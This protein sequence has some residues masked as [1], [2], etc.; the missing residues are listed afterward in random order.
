MV[1]TNNNFTGLMI[2]LLISLLFS[3]LSYWQ[4]NRYKEKLSLISTLQ[5]RIKESPLELKN[6]SANTADFQNL[7]YRRVVLEGVFKP[8]Y[9]M[10]VRNRR[11]KNIS[12]VLS[13]IP[14]QIAET[15]QIV[16]VSRG[17]IPLEYSNAKMRKKFDPDKSLT[18]DLIGIVKESSYQKLFAPSDPESGI[19]KPWI[20]A[21]LRVDLKNI[22]KQLP[23]KILPFY[24]EL[25]E[26]N[27]SAEL[28]V[29]QMIKKNSEKH[30]M[31][32][33]AGHRAVYNDSYSDLNF[34]TPLPDTYV[35]AGRHFEYVIEWAVMGLGV[36]GAAIFFQFRKG[37]LYK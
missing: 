37:R 11:Y 9:S 17:F 32:S 28:L 20:D 5:A 16:L 36:L 10:V 22:Q 23:F 14:F 1:K 29:E 19:N 24:I 2:A 13:L 35:S 7:I 30:E 27:T 8:E 15:S 21:W 3:R 12:G 33:L 34:P 4:W 18:K 25:L 31:L 6:I 26:P